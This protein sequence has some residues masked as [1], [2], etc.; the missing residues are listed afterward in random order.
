[1]CVCVCLSVCRC[2]DTNGVYSNRWVQLR[3]AQRNRTCTLEPVWVCILWE[4]VTY[5]LKRPKKWI[6][7]NFSDGLCLHH[8]GGLCVCS[9]VEFLIGCVYRFTTNSRQ[10]KCGK[11]LFAWYCCLMQQIA[12]PVPGLTFFSRCT[13]PSPAWARELIVRWRV[14]VYT[15]SARSCRLSLCLSVICL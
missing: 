15:T 14:W 6:I 3:L 7:P 13:V 9:M 12:I 10:R 2:V 8:H 11:S 4:S 1:V 5:Y